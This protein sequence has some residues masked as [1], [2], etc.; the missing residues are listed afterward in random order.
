MQSTK[1]EFAMPRFPELADC[2]FYHRMVLPDVGEVGEEWDLRPNVNAYLGET[3]FAGKRVLEIG[4]AS[5]FLT[6]YMEKAGAEVVSIDLPV[7]YGWDV[8]PR[9]G[10][11]QEWLDQRRAHLQRL[12]NGFWFTHARLGLK[13]RVIYGRVQDLTDSIGKFDIAVI[14]AVLIHCRDPMGV[15]CRCCELATQRVVVSE[16]IWRKI[17][18]PFPVMA[19]I[20]SPSNDVCDVWWNIPSDTVVAMLQMMG[21]SRT[22]VINQEQWQCSQQKD[23]PVYAAVG[24][25]S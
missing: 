1:V 6:A 25:R 17:M 10:L 18:A 8:V 13:S 14:A 5:G 9:P 20:P 7:D 23:I 11:R 16:G 19:M 12:H 22:R 3:D 21:F 24:D 2:Y 15:L 4:P